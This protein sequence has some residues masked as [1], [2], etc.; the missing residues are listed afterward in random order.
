MYPDL[1]SV[2]LIRLLLKLALFAMKLLLRPTPQPKG[3]DPGETEIDP[4]P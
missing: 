1:D 3:G 4:D 2:I